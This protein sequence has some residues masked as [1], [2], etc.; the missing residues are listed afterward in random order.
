[1]KK[2]V[3]KTM[4]TPSNQPAAQQNG[5]DDRIL[6]ELLAKKLSDLAPLHGDMIKLLTTVDNMKTTED[7]LKRFKEKIV[8][9]EKGL[10]SKIQ[11]IEHN[12]ETMEKDVKLINDNLDSFPTSH[13]LATSDAGIA[14]LRDDHESLKKQL[15]EICGKNM[16]ELS[17]LMKL[18]SNMSK[19]YWA[20]I[21]SAVL[22]IGKLLLD[23]FK[24]A[25]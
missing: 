8:D 22:S 12:I 25:H 11:G 9:P 10:F 3:A 19:V 13:D 21:A 14:K 15:E 20:L 5:N 4:T 18:K 23:V 6:L 1:M 24:S 7:E 2:G 17:A 16:H